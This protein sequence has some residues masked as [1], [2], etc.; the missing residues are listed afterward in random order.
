MTGSLRGPRAKVE[1]AKQHI[2]D[3]ETTLGG[4]FAT[5]SHD[6]HPDLILREVDPETQKAFYKLGHELEVPDA[7]STIAGD[8]VHNLRSAFDLL[9]RQLFVAN[10]QKPGED[11]FPTAGSRERF[12]ARCK[13]EIHRNVGQD[14]FD[15]IKATEAYPGGNGDT[16]W[17]IHQ[18]DIE[19][20]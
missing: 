18:L 14:A 3:L 7:I 4:T 12:V 20:K 10:G 17:R 6:T 19:D 5:V 16:I 9:L 15:L 8:V 2:N 13:G 1:R 11:Y